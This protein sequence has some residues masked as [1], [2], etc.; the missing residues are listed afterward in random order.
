MV[1]DFEMQDGVLTFRDAIHLP[2]DH[3]FTDEEIEAMKQKRFD[4]WLAI[5][6]AP[7][8]EQPVQEE[9]ALEEAPP[10]DGV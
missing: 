1:I 7:P 10:V 5:I 6:H 9:I 8:V 3:S 4:N 2:D